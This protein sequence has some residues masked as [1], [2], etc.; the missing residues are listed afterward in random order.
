M[1][2]A[3]M[4]ELFEDPNTEYKLKEIH[5]Y[6]MILSKE[7]WGPGSYDKW[8]R[9]GWALKNTHE[10]LYLTWMKMSC[11]AKISVLRVMT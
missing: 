4:T 1:L 9:V 7:Y 3:M 6:T 8:I 10:D 11:Q 5:N 2:D